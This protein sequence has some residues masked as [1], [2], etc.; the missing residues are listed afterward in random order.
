M[1]KTY[2]LITI[3]GGLAGSAFA[4][5]MAERGFSALVLERDT[6]FKNRVRVNAG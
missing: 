2:D 3:G 4:G 1:A 6:H 5:A